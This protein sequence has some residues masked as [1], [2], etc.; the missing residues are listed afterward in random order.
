MLFRRLAIAYISSVGI[1]A[2]GL[3]AILG[4]GRHLRAPAAVG[5][6]WDLPTEALTRIQSLCP[7]SAG[8]IEQR[9][10]ISQSGRYL[11]LAIGQLRGPGTIENDH[12]TAPALLPSEG[13]CD[14]RQVSFVFDA[15][16]PSTDRPAVFDGSLKLS[17]CPDCVAVRFHAVRR[18]DASD[19]Q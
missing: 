18:R 16:L 2:L 9:L 13:G 19:R 5:G 6:T 11:D 14:A 15:Q 1:P 4:G 3:I 12:V 7:D 17:H 10:D 8:S